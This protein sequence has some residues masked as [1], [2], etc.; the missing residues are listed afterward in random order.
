MG[1]MARSR[2]GAGARRVDI[3]RD[4]PDKWYPPEAVADYLGVPLNSLALGIHRGEVFAV[5]FAGPAG[6]RV[7]LAEVQRWMRAMGEAT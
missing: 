2:H 5:K 3:I 1:R 7:Q 4:A 6:Y